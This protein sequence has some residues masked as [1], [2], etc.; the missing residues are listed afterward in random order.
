MKNG[1][2]AKQNSVSSTLPATVKWSP[3]CILGKEEHII[4][5]I[6][7]LKS[8]SVII[9][10]N[11]SHCTFFII[12]C[13]NSMA[14]YKLGRRTTTGLYPYLL[15]YFFNNVLL[16]LWD[17]K[18]IHLWSYSFPPPTLPRSSIH[19]T[20]SPLPPLPPSLLSNA[21]S[22]SEWDFIGTSA[23][24][25]YPSTDFYLI[26]YLPLLC[27]KKTWKQFVIHSCLEW[28]NNF[29]ND[30]FW[31]LW[32]YSSLTPYQGTELVVLHW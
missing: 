31:H 29:Y 20:L 13:I 15:I 3:S 11:F 5:T 25:S 14:L 10:I 23:P 7:D 27:K 16:I 32:T 12:W 17:F 6:K 1:F 24:P 22:S 30:T 2:C 26:N 9:P 28:Y 18:T 4:K 8:I 21:N 19:L